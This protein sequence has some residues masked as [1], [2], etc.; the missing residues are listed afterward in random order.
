[1]Y[2][3]C[4]DPGHGGS[5]RANRG[6]TGYVEAD[7]VLAISRLVRD[8]LL[9][10]GDFQ[11]KLTRE[12]D[13]S[14]GLRQRA[15]IGAD[16]KADL[17]ISIH[18]DAY[19]GKSRGPVSFYSVD[20]PNDKPLAA[21]LTASIAKA[22]GVSDRGAR[23]RPA[24]PKRPGQTGA[25]VSNPED[26]YAVIDQAQDRRIPHVIL[27]ECLMHDNPM[28]E[29]ILKTESGR[30]T[31]AKC[32]AQCIAATFAVPYPPL[33]GVAKDL[34]MLNRRL[35]SAGKQQLDSSY[36]ARMAVK[37]QTVPGE[38]V[39]AFIARMAMLL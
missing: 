29:A 27:I 35:A 15:N 4:I 18:T 2:R 26:Y 22:I 33:A 34:D 10:T 32:I 8:E 25:T 21:R 13:S 3:I 9:S 36:W 23:T 14:L 31:I 7:G 5:D 19:N 24:D 11:V 38:L 6:P 16:F 1:V 30:L 39:A 37:G 20:L 17:F 12:G 28:D